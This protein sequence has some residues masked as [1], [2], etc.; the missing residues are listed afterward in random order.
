LLVNKTKPVGAKEKGEIKMKF[1][2]WLD[3]SRTTLLILFILFWLIHQGKAQVYLDST[4]S[5]D[6][7]VEDLLGRM[8]LEEKIGQMAQVVYSHLDG[9]SDIQNDCLGSVLATADL[10]PPGKS[11]EA[12]ADCHDRLQSQALKT[13]LGIPLLFGI[14]AV[15]GIGSVHGATIFPHHIGLGCTRS[16]EWVERAA[17]ITAQETSATGIDWTFGPVVAVARNIRWG[18]TY[19]SF[20]ED[21]TLVREMAAAAV[22]GF[23]G[24]TLSDQSSILACAKHFIGDGGTTDGQNGMN[25]QIDEQTLRTVHMQ[26]YISAIQENVGSIMIS[27]S[28]WNGQQCHGNRYLITTV[29]KEELG[30]RGIVLSDYCSFLLAGDYVNDYPGTV[31]NAINSGMDMAMIGDYSVFDYHTFLAA[32][33]TQTE[34][35]IIPKGRIDDAVR[36]ILKQ[37]FLLGLFEHPYAHRSQLSGVGSTQ[38][39]EVARECVRRSLVLLKRKDNVLP[40]SKNLKRIHVGGRHADNMGYQ[41]GGWTITWQGSS[42]DVTP[43][44]TILKA[45]QNAASNTNVTY[46]TDG[47]G[48]EGVDL[49]IAVI[50]EEPYAEGAGD[51][52][53]L[54][55][56]LEDVLTVRQMKETGIP[57]VVILLSGRPLIL[58]P[59]LHYCDAL[60]AAWLPGTEG[61]GVADVLF[62]DVQPSG[63]LSQTW[64]KAFSQIPI[65]LGDKKYDPLFAYGYGITSFDNSL[66][67]SAPR[68]LSAATSMDGLSIE[69]TFNKEM[70]DPSSDPKGFAITVNTEII[71]DIR[72][73][74]LKKRDATTICLPLRNRAQKGDIITVSY[75]PG[76]VQSKDQGLL[77]AFQN[78]PVYNIFNDYSNIIINPGLIEAEQFLSRNGGAFQGSDSPSGT[79]MAFADDIGWLKYYVLVD[80]PGQYQLDY[81]I[82]SSKTA[83][84][85][86]FIGNGAVLSAMELPVTGSWNTWQTVST[87][88]NL[89]Q[90]SQILT[91][92]IVKSGFRID[93]LNLTLKTDVESG[94]GKPVHWEL[95][96]NFPNPFNP[97]TTIKYSIPQESVVTL[98]IYN[99]RGQAIETLVDKRQNAGDYGI[100]FN[101]SR[102]PS[103]IYMYELKAGNFID[104][105]K[106]AL[107]K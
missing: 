38:H 2:E 91:L 90:G 77:E 68:F 96:Q 25:T 31:A 51:K 52:N 82:S 92:M 73:V 24:D 101:G 47:S 35:D 84:Q 22:R 54:D 70:A 17:R 32:V 69:L 87:T 66:T 83:G 6:A 99:V 14:D 15:H 13:R 37:K 86:E 36:R 3:R 44:T 60:I 39:R 10:G 56:S 74:L 62:G 53:Q 107:V 57:L 93:W 28:Q 11:A 89:P 33:K 27:Q 41:C 4:A 40:V 5:V 94:K 105:K 58:D 98:K 49:G 80:N 79:S 76:D 30:F 106:L 16:P 100:L 46:S 75:A 29:L 72:E 104:I 71:G 26:G 102:L 97:V 9:E 21:P 55:I 19:E 34:K 65:H 23:Q 64:P 95:S 43:G 85:V 61:Q 81:R 18:R 1:R 59:I 45:I 50:G 88:V 103:G 8:T 67:G 20:G 78:Q 12:W 63:L 7:R 42:G 48:A